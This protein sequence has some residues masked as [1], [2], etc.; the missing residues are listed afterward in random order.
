[1]R[2]PSSAISP[3]QNAPLATSSITLGPDGM[4]RFSIRRCALP[5]ITP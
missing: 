3:N 1:M 2:A 4:T 5:S